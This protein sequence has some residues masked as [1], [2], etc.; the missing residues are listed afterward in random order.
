MKCFDS[1][2]DL[3]GHTPLVKLDRL[4]EPGMATVLAKLEQ[5]NPGGS[6]KD[7][8][9]IHM[10]RKAEARGR[11]KPGATLIESTS[12]NTGM[13]VAMAAAV[14]GYRCVFTIPDKMSKEKIDSLK[15][16]GAEVLVTRTDLSHEHPESYVGIARRLASEIPNSLYIDQYHNMDNPEAHYLTTGP[17]V[18]EDTD[19]MIDA[20]VGG[21]GTGGTISGAGKYLKEQAAKAG[22]E[23]QIVCPDPVGSIYADVFNNRPITPPR[24]Y[25][26]EG[27]GHDFMVDTLDFSVIDEVLPVTDRDSLL[28]ARRLVREEG[29]FAGGS[30]GTAVFGALDVARRLGP[31]KIVVVIIPDTGARYISKCFDDDWMRDMGFIGEHERLGT[32]RELLQAKGRNVEFARPDDSIAHVVARMGELGYSQMPLDTPAGQPRRMIHEIDLLKAL[33]GGKCTHDEPVSRVA[34][35]LQGEVALRD[36]LAKV[37]EVFDDDNIAIVVENGEVIGIITKIDVVEF[38]ARRS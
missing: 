4:V 28:T 31:E 14:L 29:V 11:I 37:Q 22:R 19:G 38:L 1:I 25:T 35:P 20:F 8:M 23:V 30:A 2:L 10:I 13:G 9:A 36:S 7:R 3:I 16:F 5:L 6:V 33:A 32:V 24:I 27:I 34:A 15:A 12:G 26:V 17:E 18:W 21:I